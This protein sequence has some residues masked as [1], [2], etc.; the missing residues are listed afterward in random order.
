LTGGQT[1]N[2]PLSLKN[3]FW[4][5]HDTPIKVTLGVKDLGGILTGEID[6]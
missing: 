5:E 3:F 2:L 1:F 4:T 6:A